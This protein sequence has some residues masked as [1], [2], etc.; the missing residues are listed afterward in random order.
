M[1]FLLVLCLLILS[2]CGKQ[3]K[4]FKKPKVSSFLNVAICSD[5]PPFAFSENDKLNG[6]DFVL[7]S[8]IA[9]TMNKKITFHDV[10][11]Q[12]I[13]KLLKSNKVD[14]AISAISNSKERAKELDFSIPYHR[15]ITVILSSFTKSIRRIEDLEEKVIGV[16]KGTTYEEYLKTT[17]KP[18]M[19]KLEI[20]YREKY[21]DLI[22]AMEDGKCDAII[23][24]YSEASEIQSNM[25]DAKIIPIEGT[26]VEY[27]IA[28]SKNSPL[29]ELVNQ[30]IEEMIASGYLRKL[31][32]RFF[33]KVV[34]K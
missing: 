30:E 2:G 20:L 32:E 15:S 12:S 16:Q 4:N 27:C 6:F 33:K 9:K 28:F 22:Q 1:R 10:D 14:M 31:E 34:T 13:F 11:F 19:K 25:P 23:T 5:Y 18:S 21:T 24:G 8:D 7:A 29:I 17:L 26:A 3:E